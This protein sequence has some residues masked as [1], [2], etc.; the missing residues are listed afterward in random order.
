MRS[1]TAYKNPHTQ[2]PPLQAFLKPSF[3]LEC[4]RLSRRRKDM[5][6]GEVDG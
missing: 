6:N 1:F 2:S 5:L 4:G 3:P